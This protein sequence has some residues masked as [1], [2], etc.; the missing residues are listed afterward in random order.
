MKKIALPLD[1]SKNIFRV[2]QLQGLQPAVYI[3]VPSSKP[4]LRTRWAD[5][6]RDYVHTIELMTKSVDYEP[7]NI[8]ILE[9]YIDRAY[10]KLLEIAGIEGLTN[11][12]HYFGRGHIIWMTRIH[13]KLWQIVMKVWKV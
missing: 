9:G 2:D 6:L 5:F 12:F 4:E 8:D 11:Y 10:T 3:A 13:G 1:Q 7:G